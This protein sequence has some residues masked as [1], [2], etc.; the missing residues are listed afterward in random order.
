M[1]GC[2]SRRTTI[3]NSRTAI[4][5]STLRRRSSCI[6]RTNTEVQRI[7][8]WS[9]SSLS[10]LISVVADP[11]VLWNPWQVSFPQQASRSELIPNQAQLSS[12]LGLFHVH[13][14]QL[15]F[16]AEKPVVTGK[17]VV[18]QTITKYLGIKYRDLCFQ[19]R[20]CYLLAYTT[21]CSTL[22]DCTK[23]GDVSL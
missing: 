23:L 4:Y 9:P 8:A 18:T 3:Y 22:I 19:E 17:P 12:Q 13:F 2:T 15:E 14:P 6:L 7:N 10:V 20:N 11:T 16:R 1:A 5:M 21:I